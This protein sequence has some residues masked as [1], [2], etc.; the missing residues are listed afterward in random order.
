M[1]KEKRLDAWKRRLK[2]RRDLVRSARAFGVKPLRLPSKKERERIQEILSVFE[3]LHART[4]VTERDVFHRSYPG[5]PDVADEHYFRFIRDV[6]SCPPEVIATAE[7]VTREWH[8][9]QIEF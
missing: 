3:A 7:T 4:K 8:V 5:K 6:L 1:D 2:G 9:Q